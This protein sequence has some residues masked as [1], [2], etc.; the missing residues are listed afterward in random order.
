MFQKENSSSYLSFDDNDSLI[1]MRDAA[2]IEVANATG[3]KNGRAYIK[4]SNAQL[5]SVASISATG[6]SGYVDVVQPVN[7][8]VLS[9]SGTTAYLTVKVRYPAASISG[10]VSDDLTGEA[11]A[12]IV[13]AA[14][15]DGANTT[16]AAAITQATSGGDGRYA[17]GFDIADSRALDVYV[18]GYDAV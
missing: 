16:T 3:V 9:L 13:V 2:G 8:T 11:V 10:Y 7:D 12:G 1:V 14:F 5:A 18:A 4:L 17:M 15:D 6:I